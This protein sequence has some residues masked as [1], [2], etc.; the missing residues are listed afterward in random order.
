[1]TAIQPN[2]YKQLRDYI[3]QINGLRSNSAA[4]GITQAKIAQLLDVDGSTICRFLSGGVQRPKKLMTNFIEQYS[5]E[6]QSW[7]AGKNT[8]E[9]VLTVADARFFLRIPTPRAV[10]VVNRPAPPKIIRPKVEKQIETQ[11]APSIAKTPTIKI[12]NRVTAAASS[13]AASSTIA[14]FPSTPR[15]PIVISYRGHASEKDGQ[16]MLFDHMRL[17]NITRRPTNVSYPLNRLRTSAESYFTKALKAAP[18]A[19]YYGE[20]NADKIKVPSGID[21]SYEGGLL[22]IPGRDRK[23]EFEPVRLDHEFKIIRQAINRGQPMIGICAGAWRVWEQLIITINNP[24]L[25]GMKLKKKINEVNLLI[26]VQDHAYRS[27]IRLNTIGVKSCN[28]VMVHLNEVKKDSLLQKFMSKRK[29]PVSIFKA[30]SVHWNAVN[31]KHKPTNITICAKAKKDPKA[32]MLN[33]QSEI[34]EPTVCV[35]AF[36]SVHGAPILG[37]QWH[38]EGYSEGQ[39]GYTQQMNLLQA[40]AKA[41]DAYKAKRIM[42]AEF[43]LKRCPI[44]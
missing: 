4:L 3:T 6:F 9:R 18:A 25:S 19:L 44:T 20:R 43:Q 17:Q 1:M 8:I 30:N 35:E 33:N 7:P 28:N 29:D 10:V 13:S 31:H 24:D 26:P 39:D 34:Y 32:T 42:L 41:G 27:M 38:P 22:V 15:A 37:I 21:H 5:T 16:G 2:Q 12:S 40:M 23:V 14:F 11:P 36:E